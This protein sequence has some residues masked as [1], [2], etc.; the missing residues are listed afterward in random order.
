MR[1]AEN[2][3]PWEEGYLVEFKEFK[4]A[5][6][7][8]ELAKTLSAFA[9]TDGGS[10]YIGVTDN[11]QIR[12][13]K[14]TPL[15]LDNI[16]NTAREVCI[17]PIPIFLNEITAEGK[18]VLKLTVE[19]SGHLH[20]VSSGHTYIRVGTQDK[21]IVGEELLRL[22]ESKSQVSF[23]ESVLPA[24]IEVIDRTA[25]DEYYLARKKVSA[26]MGGL[27]EEGLLIKMGLAKRDRG[28]FKIKAGA[29][30]LFGKEHEQIL[31]QRDFTFVKYDVEGRMYSYREDLSAPAAKLLE[32]L[33]ELIRPC[34]KITEGVRG[35]K[36]QERYIYP[37]DAVR[38]VIVNAV[39][40]RDY[41]IAGLK[42]E[43]RI[44]P[45]RLEV[46]SAGNLPGTITL[47]NIDKRHYS[48]NPKIMHALLIMGL[49]E[50][51]GQGISMMKHLLKANGNP[52]PEFIVNSDQFKVIFY[53]QKKLSSKG[54]AK[55]ILD[56]YFEASELISRRQ[57]E[58]LCGIG[59][60]TAKYLLEKLTGEGYL[61][62]V[63]RG[64][65][66]QYKKV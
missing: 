25:L 2:N 37:E 66:T 43:C 31:L 21:R 27:D 50:E 35:V 42:N 7:V 29:F 48:R 24:G 54:D 34:N 40:H 59:S 5:I 47:E 9:N 10:V 53:R 52:P 57:V 36:R 1:E 44:Y 58:S 12:G 15:L 28:E 46:I 41:R 63:G 3:I 19:K 60:T 30:I 51:L 64:P 45:D 23:E 13:V 22:A 61:R 11:R 38:E 49:T 14:I 20:S 62:R 17:P 32:R 33:M 39:A 16:Q 18:I 65:V 56:D 55:K 4:G 6:S 8:K 26:V